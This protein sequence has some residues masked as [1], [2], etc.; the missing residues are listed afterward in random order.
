MYTGN[1]AETLTFE[2]FYGKEVLDEITKIIDSN[3]VDYVTSSDLSKLHDHH[4]EKWKDVDPNVSK[5][6]FSIDKAID[7]S[8]LMAKE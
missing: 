1:R 7:Q 2:D 5:L 4:N 6:H 3:A 8:C